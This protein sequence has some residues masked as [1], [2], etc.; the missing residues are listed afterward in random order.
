MEFDR[1]RRRKGYQVLVRLGLI[2]Y[3]L[4]SIVTAGLAL[5][6]AGG[7]DA[8]ASSAGALREVS[9]QPLG[10]VLVWSMSVGMLV[11]A[12]WQ[13][14][15]AALGGAN[16][17]RWTRRV[18]SLGRA[19]T[20]AF[21]GFLA[22]GTATGADRQDNVGSA[23]T[24][25]ILDLRFGRLPVGVLLIVAVGMAVVAVGVSQILRGVRRRFTEDL[26]REAGR[27]TIVFGVV[28]LTAKGLVLTMIGSLLVA[29]AVTRDPSDV[30]GMDV[31]LARLEDQAF[32]PLLLVVMAGGLA[33]FGLYCFVWSGRARV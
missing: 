2:S 20:Y 13:V 4:V 7:G 6:V 10:V 9:S 22:L 31:A 15:E 24:A 28:G 27:P 26:T 17:T 3:G 16:G 18:S 11:L 1:L 8:R 32:G 12:L 14:V 33:C 23:L 25:Q 29:A 19:T 5:Q 21:L 30:G